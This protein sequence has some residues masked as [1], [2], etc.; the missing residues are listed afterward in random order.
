MIKL[1]L[2]G[3]DLLIRH[4]LQMRLAHEPDIMVIGEA[5]SS[6]N[7]AEV[8]PLLQ[9]ECPDVVVMDLVRPDLNEMKTMAMLRTI[10]PGCPVI[11]LSLYDEKA[12][13]THALSQG[14]VAFVGK[15]EGV[16]ALLAAIRQVSHH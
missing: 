5:S 12:L 16:S 7:E 10:C 14:A 11:I 13:R 9:M 2:I 15:C 4:G 8:L 3:N 1:L 6:A